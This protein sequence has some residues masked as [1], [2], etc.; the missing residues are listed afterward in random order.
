MIY[1]RDL[2]APKGKFRIVLLDK[3]EPSGEGFYPF[4]DYDA[5][6]EA[7]KIARQKG[8]EAEPDSSDPNIATVYYV[9][10]DKGVYKGGDIYKDE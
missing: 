6:D 10:D 3:F 5:L 2:K 8:K 9:F 1:R 4:G 7:L